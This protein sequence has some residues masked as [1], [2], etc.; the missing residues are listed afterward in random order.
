M[1]KIGCLSDICRVVQNIGDYELIGGVTTERALGQWL[2][3]T[4]QLKVRFPEKVRPYLD[5][6]FIGNVYHDSHNGVFTTEGYVQRRRNTPAMVE[7]PVF[8]LTLSKGDK[9]LSLDL[10]SADEQLREVRHELKAASFEE[11]ELLDIRARPDMSCLTELVPMGNITVEDANA[12]SFRIRNMTQTE[13]DF[14]KYC[15]ALAMEEPGTFAEAL[16]IA[17]SIDDYERVPE[18]PAEYAVENLR[19]AGAGDEILH[20]LAG[21]TDLRK[22]GEDIAKQ[23]GVCQTEYG[24]V[25]R[26]SEPFPTEEIGQTMS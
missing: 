22:L 4:E 13:G 16:D 14:L 26:L 21:Y 11:T 23:E 25:R 2:V 5:Y 10:P 17:I 24:S 6:D 20:M 9:T 19:L 18:D 8:R 3:K 1:E 12:L 15:S 7:G